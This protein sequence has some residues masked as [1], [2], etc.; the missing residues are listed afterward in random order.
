MLLFAPPH[1]KVAPLL[2]SCGGSLNLGGITENAFPRPMHHS[3]PVWKSEHQMFITGVCAFPFCIALYHTSA[4]AAEELGFCMLWV[5]NFVWWRWVA[6]VSNGLGLVEAD[7][8]KNKTP[9][10]I[11]LPDASKNAMVWTNTVTS[12]LVKSIQLWKYIGV[13]KNI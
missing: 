8:L 2:P 13:N 11:Y 4:A 3:W 7:Y 9:D 6:A 10:N 5:R 12:N 1:L